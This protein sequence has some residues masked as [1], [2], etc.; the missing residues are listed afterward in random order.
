[1]PTSD[2]R[3]EPA[4]KGDNRL[5]SIG[6]ASGSPRRT[7]RTEGANQFLA[8]HLR[9]PVLVRALRRADVL[10]FEPGRV[11]RNTPPPPSGAPGQNRLGETCQLHFL[12]AT[13]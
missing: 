3:W 6:Q 13:K 5:V 9:R 1:M 7:R 2:G 8:P 12:C 11:T 4:F 10:A